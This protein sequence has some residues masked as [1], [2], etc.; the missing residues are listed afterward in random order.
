MCQV[1]GCDGMAQA[2]YGEM[3]VCVRCAEE[4]YQIPPRQAVAGLWATVALLA[5]IVLIAVKVLIER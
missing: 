5:A 2:K 1:K 3:D 4:L